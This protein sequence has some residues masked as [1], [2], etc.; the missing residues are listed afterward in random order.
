MFRKPLNFLHF[1]LF[2]PIS[3]FSTFHL[4]HRANEISKLIYYGP[5]E[6]KMQYL[7]IKMYEKRENN[8]KREL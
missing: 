7:H 6:Q 8:V 4:R 5:V 1:S 3:I 2:I